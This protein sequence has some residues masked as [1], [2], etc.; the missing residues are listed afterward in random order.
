[1]CFQGQLQTFNWPFFSFR[2]QPGSMIVINV[3][4]ERYEDINCVANLL[5][6]NIADCEIAKVEMISTLMNV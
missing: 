2:I 1:M 4:G 6:G 3:R 5:C